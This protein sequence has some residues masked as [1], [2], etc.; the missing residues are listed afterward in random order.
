[1][2][3]KRW[4]SAELFPT[5]LPIPPEM[6]IGRADDV[7]QIAQAL[8][9]GGHIVV[10][11]PRR[12]GKTSVC[13]AA[14][15]ACAQAGCYTAAVDLFHLADAAELAEALTVRVLANRP[16]LARAI[17]A[18]E[19]VPARLREALSVAATYRARA[20]LG[21]DLEI[22]IS[23][24]AAQAEPDRALR[25][26]L[27][28]LERIA[29]ADDKRLV[30]FFDEFQDITSGLFG[31]PDVVT[32]RLRAILQRSPHVSVLFAGS[33]EH[34]MRDLFAPGERALSQFGAFHELHAIRTSEWRDGIRARLKLDR[35]TIDDSALERLIELGEGH[36]RTTML[37]AQQAHLIAAGELTRKLDSAIVAAALAAAM[38]A[39]RLKH[40][41]TLERIRSISRYSQR[42]AVRVA[43][44]EKLY[45][46]I[47]PQN[48]RRAL[49]GLRDAGI[50]E[51]TGRRGGW[52][53]LDPLVRRYLA[54][55]RA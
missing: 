51:A 43:T 29:A 34:L 14:V 31:K 7:D 37:L 40:E 26:G 28:L 2:S 20:D 18:A 1:M 53:V 36:P 16:V 54:E 21:E 38:R 15:A 41:Q 52:M 47:A 24:Q 23:P 48:A 8:A 25:T 5:D 42:L 13:D 44:G 4:G 11:G 49:K 46:G 19:G 50:V 12:T 55:L 22:T 33:M 9:G 10:A 35:R 39:D 17:H 6:M 32:R 30:V 45:E 3:D 27:E